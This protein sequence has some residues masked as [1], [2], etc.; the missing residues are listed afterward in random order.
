MAIYSLF[1][2]ILREVLAFL[3]LLR[4]RYIVYLFARSTKS[5][6]SLDLTCTGGFSNVK[7]GAGSRINSFSQ[8]RNMDD[9]V[10]YIG[11]NVYCGSGLILVAHTYSRNDDHSR[12]NEMLSN[13][14]TIS[15]DVWIGSRVI[16]MPGVHIGQGAVVGAGAVVTKDVPANATVGG[17]PAKVL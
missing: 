11:S 17:V 14:I 12:S 8:F 10:I 5:S 7:I 1:R 3:L 6:I 2:F 4:K 13:S 16:I 9:S 15:D